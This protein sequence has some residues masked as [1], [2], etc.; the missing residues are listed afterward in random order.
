VARKWTPLT[1]LVAMRPRQWIKNI[2]LF[3]GLYF[4]RNLLDPVSVQRTLAAFIIFCLLSGSIY[5]LNDVIDAPRDRLH[6]QKRH[7]PVAS[8]QL[9]ATV[10]LRVALVSTGGALAAGF[11]LSPFFGMCCVAYILMMVAYS[12]ALKEVFLIDT[13]IIAMGFVIRAVSGVI[14][15]RTADLSVP[16]TTWFV[17]CVMFLSLLLAFCKRRSE[18]RTLNETASDF[19]PVLSHYSLALVD[20]GITIC[21]GGAI[22]SYTLYATTTDNTWVMLTT[23]PFV[24]YGIFRYLHLVFNCED[25]EAPEKVLTSDLPLLGCVVL[26]GLSLVLVY[27]PTL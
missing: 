7:R 26:W 15:L 14:V 2:L 19:R 18:R 22:L 20:S 4:S 27:F 25:G 13:M 16:L 5:L 12:L 24:L 10:A 21:A 23:L 17:V 6:P 1:L 11:W 9:P 3:A 8:G